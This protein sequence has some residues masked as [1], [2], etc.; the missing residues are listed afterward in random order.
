MLKPPGGPRSVARSRVI[1]RR[2]H[3]DGFSSSFT[4]SNQGERRARSA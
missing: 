3:Q 1:A 4:W 2:F